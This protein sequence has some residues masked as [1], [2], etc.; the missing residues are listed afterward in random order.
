MITIQEKN[1]CVKISTP[2]KEMCIPRGTSKPQ[3]TGGEFTLF[4]DRISDARS[5]H[6]IFKV[7]N[8]ADITSVTDKSGDSIPITTIEQMSKDIAK[9]FI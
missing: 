2:S 1:D 3:F 9:F 8:V 5:K 7:G 6:P 4:E